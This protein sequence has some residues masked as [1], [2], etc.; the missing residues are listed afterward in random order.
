MKQHDPEGL[1]EHRLRMIDEVIGDDRYTDDQKQ[2]LSDSIEGWSKDRIAFDILT[3]KP[4]ESAIRAK[5]GLEF[6]TSY[7]PDWARRYA[8]AEAIRNQGSETEIFTSTPSARSWLNPNT[9]GVSVATT[10]NA[11][12]VKRSKNPESP[13]VNRLADK[14][15]S[16]LRL[17]TREY[18]NKN[19]EWEALAE[20][21]GFDDP[22]K[23]REYKEQ[24]YQ[25]LIGGTSITNPY[26]NV[27]EVGPV[28]QM[29]ERNIEIGTLEKFLHHGEVP[30]ILP[31][32]PLRGQRL[33]SA[34]SPTL[35]KFLTYIDKANEQII[36]REVDQPL[37]SKMNPKMATIDANFQ[38][39][40][41]PAAGRAIVLAGGDKIDLEEHGAKKENNIDRSIRIV[42]VVAPTAN[43][44][45][46]ATLH[47]KQEDEEGREHFGTILYSDK[48]FMASIINLVDDE[49]L[50]QQ[51]ELESVNITDTH[52][53][54]DSWGKGTTVKARTPDTF[55]IAHNGQH[56]SYQK[57]LEEIAPT[58]EQQPEK[59]ERWIEDVAMRIIEDTQVDYPQ[60]EG[61]GKL[62][63]SKDLDKVVGII[64]W[65]LSSSIVDS[66][67]KKQYS[68]AYPQEWATENAPLY[69]AL[70]KL[71][72]RFRKPEFGAEIS[73]RLQ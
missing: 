16:K 39:A 4:I 46:E 19:R 50:K 12:E 53:P 70:V 71:P 2:D 38:R 26:R 1:E 59:S 13:F 7:L 28:D 18:L 27:G 52:T 29:F 72:A 6:K 33:Q 66:E 32:E 34:H 51:F 54:I 58:I 22:A 37:E 73:A 45:W 67:L 65:T 55:E 44:N 49:E 61:L 25:V 8:T 5:T 21:A 56:V 9:R 10:M 23:K 31:V 68:D 14:D 64:K 42:G 36:T 24:L 11:I 43:N 17:L 69:K 63:I 57:V 35:Q 3:R 62:D 47:V 41:N 40:F 60:L 48:K 15:A 30:H 20:E